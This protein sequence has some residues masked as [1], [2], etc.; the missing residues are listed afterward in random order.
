MT[1]TEAIR[2]CI[3]HCASRRDGRGRWRAENTCAARLISAGTSA[4]VADACAAAASRIGAWLATADG[5]KPTRW[6]A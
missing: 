6:T 5:P 3:S 4:T 2:R 1:D